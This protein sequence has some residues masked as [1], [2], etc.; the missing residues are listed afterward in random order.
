MNSASLDSYI[1]GNYG[2]DSVAPEFVTARELGDFEAT[3]RIVIDV[4]PHTGEESILVTIESVAIT[5]GL[6]YIKTKE[7]A[8]EVVIPEGETVW[9]A[10]E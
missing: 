7:L 4:A 3:D 1:T 5:S 6:V 9:F 8:W 2:E 10:D